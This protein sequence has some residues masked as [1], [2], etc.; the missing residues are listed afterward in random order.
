MTAEREGK[1]SDAQAPA[2]YEAGLLLSPKE[3]CSQETA[4]KIPHHLSLL[5]ANANP[6][7]MCMS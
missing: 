4:L 7:H 5:P 6:K 2:V 3:N 1:V